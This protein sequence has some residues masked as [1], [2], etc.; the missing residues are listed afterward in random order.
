MTKP[1]R[2]THDYRAPRR[3]RRGKCGAIQ[4][5]QATAGKYWFLFSIQ[6]DR[7]AEARTCFLP[8]L[9]LCVRLAD[10][11]AEASAPNSGHVNIGM[12]FA[13]KFQLASVA[14]RS[15]GGNSGRRTFSSWW[16]G[17]R[18]GLVPRR[19]RQRR[20]GYDGAPPF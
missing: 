20:A 11:H 5:R 9:C 18:R 8:A 15:A 16:M 1:S 4:A 17:I 13:L 14:A 12:V 6:P 10:S 7:E 3:D 2:L 19:F